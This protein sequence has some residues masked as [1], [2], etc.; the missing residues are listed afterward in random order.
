MW[1]IGYVPEDLR[2][3]ELVSVGGVTR[4]G[5]LKA[6][7]AGV[8]GFALWPY[9][10]DEGARAFAR[11][12]Q[13]QAPPTLRFLTPAQYKDLDALAEAIIPAD[14]HSPGARAARVAD[15]I[16][17]LLSESD[18]ETQATWTDG[19]SEVDRLSR[20]RFQAS[21]ALLNAAQ[22]TELL[23]EMSKHERDPQSGLE[24]FFKTTKEATVRG[25]YTSEIGIHKELG[26]KGN[27]HL[28]EFV[29]CKTVD[30]EPCP[31]CG[32]KP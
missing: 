12:Q 3:Q 25:Y 13:S 21:F 22:T 2:E 5:A 26:Y 7:G 16:D 18:E 19:L 32:Q 14:R 29:G 1:R 15:Y 28:P 10:S 6:L 4:R 30:G 20:E 24:K 9:L 8:G 31:H 11:I 17:L 23:T 27:Q